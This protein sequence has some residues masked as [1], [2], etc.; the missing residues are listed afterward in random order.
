MPVHPA[1]HLVFVQA[2][3]PV[4]RLKA[5][6]DRPSRPGGP[7]QLLARSR[8]RPAAQVAR[9]FLR[10]LAT[11]SHQQPESPPPF[12]D[13]AERPAVPDYWRWTPTDLTPFL[14]NSVSSTISTP[15][16]SAR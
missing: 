4:G 3:V 6:L 7:D 10:L 11:P 16:G 13:R 2:A 12:V 15:R 1:A 9:A 14:R 5:L 8:G